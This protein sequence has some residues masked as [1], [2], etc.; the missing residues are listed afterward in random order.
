[1]LSTLPPELL[2]GI[3]EATIPHSFHSTTYR[4]RQRTL[5]QLSLVSKLFREIAQ[6]LLLEI[7]WINSLQQFELFK[8][9]A[10]GG[11]GQRQGT[12]I[13]QAVLRFDIFPPSS[14]ESWAS[15]QTTSSI[16][17]LTFVGFTGAVPSS[18]TSE[19][20]HHL[21]SLQIKFIDCVFD[22]PVTLPNLRSLA[23]DSVPSALT[24]VL[25][26]PIV[27]PKLRNLSLDGLSDD[28]LNR[29]S[30]PRLLPQ[31]ETLFCDIALWLY[32]T[33]TFLHRAADKTLI[34]SFPDTLS[35][36]YF[37]QP[38][39]TFTHLR[40]KAAASPDRYGADYVGSE[41]NKFA[42]GLDRTPSTLQ[43]LYLHSSLQDPDTSSS[44]LRQSVG[45]LVGACHRK[46]IEVIF[47]EGPND[48]W[49]DP[50][51]SPDFVRRQ[52]KRR[53]VQGSGRLKG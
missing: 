49:I 46:K 38:P 40:I 51:I 53:E 15:P 25:L 23:L 26:D 16:T 43:V 11:S 37:E 22:H 48:F 45:R 33:E 47:E 18:W 44:L 13:K 14:E 6:A 27:L 9:G 30:L 35:T 4:D 29:S 28:A 10:G 5:R 19:S 42:S 2:R 20:L 52:Q 31:L 36:L 32:S 50:C 39:S 3:I 21:T 7:V 17:A 8:A 41:L 24:S 12:S 1:M 34:D